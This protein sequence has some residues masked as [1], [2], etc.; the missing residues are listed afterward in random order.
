MRVLRKSSILTMLKLIKPSSRVMLSKVLSA[1][2]GGINRRSE[3]C[4]K[5]CRKTLRPTSGVSL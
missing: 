5:H 1:R 3:V 2:S 4:K